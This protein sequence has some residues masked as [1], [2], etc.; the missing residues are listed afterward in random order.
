MRAYAGDMMPYAGD[1]SLRAALG[2]EVGPNIG[3]DYQNTSNDEA[4]A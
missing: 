3:G 4:G 2:R 1:M